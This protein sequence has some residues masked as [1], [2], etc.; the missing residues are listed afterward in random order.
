MSYHETYEFFA[1]DQC[2]TPTAMRTLRVISSRATITPA[3][4]YNSYDW[5]GLNGDPR[6][7]L[8]RYFDLFVHTGNGRPEW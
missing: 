4:F 5:G 3:R 1:I 2:L 6:E 7:I 8:R